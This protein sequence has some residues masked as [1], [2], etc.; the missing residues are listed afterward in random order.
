MCAQKRNKLLT[1][2]IV[3][4]PRC[5]FGL[6]V[7]VGNR[8]LGV[9][10]YDSLVGFAFAKKPICLFRWVVKCL[11]FASQIFGSSFEGFAWRNS[12]FVISWCMSLHEPYVSVWCPLKWSFTTSFVLA[13]FPALASHNLCGCWLP[14][15]ASIIR[16]GLGSMHDDLPCLWIEFCLYR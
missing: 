7:R 3:P 13:N 4:L 6:H 16:L 11:S 15:I 5:P 10:V 14:Y 1:S 8:S 2:W 12:S 9:Q